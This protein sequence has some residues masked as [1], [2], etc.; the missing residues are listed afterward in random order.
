MLLTRPRVVVRYPNTNSFLM[1]TIIN[2][3]NDKN[4][5]KCDRGCSITF[6]KGSRNIIGSVGKE[7]NTE[8]LSKIEAIESIL[9]NLKPFMGNPLKKTKYEKGDRII[10][11]HE[12][13]GN[14]AATIKHV[15]NTYTVAWDNSKYPDE[16]VDHETILGL[17][18]DKK[19]SNQIPNKLLKEFLV[20]SGS[21]QIIKETP[22]KISKIEPLNEISD[23]EF[24]EVTNDKSD[25]IIKELNS[26]KKKASTKGIS[27]KEKIEALQDQIKGTIELLANLNKELAELIVEKESDDIGKE[28]PIRVKVIKEVAPPVEEIEKPVEIVKTKIHEIPDTIP[29]DDMDEDEGDI[30]D[31]PKT[32]KKI[33]VIKD[34]VSS[35]DGQRDGENRKWDGNKKRLK[36]IENIKLKNRRKLEDD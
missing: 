29:K 3:V 31:E 36:I 10:L 34:S 26:F 18:I 7:K 1:G 20:Q 13:G 4:I 16:E 22:H 12:G 35:E 24:T 33:K 17:A 32:N 9:K 19:R 23:S 30:V 15:S 21:K 5:V 2:Q 8:I 27:R 11:I 25:E 6:N 14:Y 28:K